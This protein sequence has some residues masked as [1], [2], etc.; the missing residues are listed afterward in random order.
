[1][2]KI[3]VIR[4][5]LELNL[6]EIK[7]YDTNINNIYIWDIVNFIDGKNKINFIKNIINNEQ[8]IIYGEEYI[9][10]IH[11]YYNKM[12]NGIFYGDV[13]NIIYSPKISKKYFVSEELTMNI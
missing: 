10:I 2:K 9:I 8:S 4:K 6:Y 11:E 7:K 3:E 1:M 5:E 12:D 13:K